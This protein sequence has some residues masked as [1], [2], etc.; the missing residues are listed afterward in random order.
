MPQAPIGLLSSAATE[1][2]LQNRRE[3][4]VPTPWG[5]AA[6][7]LGEI[8]G[9]EAAVVLRYGANLTVPSH[10]INH[11]AN[12]WAFRELGATSIISQNA[13]GSVSRAIRPGDIVISDDFLDRTKSRALSLYDDT[14]AWVRVDMTEPFCPRLR[15]A[16]IKAAS[17]RS[18]RVIARGV[19][20]CTEGPV[21]FVTSTVMRPAEPAGSTAVIRPSFWRVNDVAFVPPNF[22]PVVAMR[23]VKFWP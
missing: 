17:A 16:L 3:E 20:V 9:R 8:G 4:R 23:P 10:R 7:L 11:Q 2:L 13:I 18:D 1:R 6:V 14:E 5:E 21:A 22:T 19:F 15:T 12:I